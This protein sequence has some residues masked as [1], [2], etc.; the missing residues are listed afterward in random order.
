VGVKLEFADGTN[1]TEMFFVHNLFTQVKNPFVK[2]LGIET[3]PVAGLE[4]G[5]IAVTPPTYQ[6]NVEWGLVYST[7]HTFLCKCQV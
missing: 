3:T 2:Q 7:V 4:I 6:T 1:T 5:D